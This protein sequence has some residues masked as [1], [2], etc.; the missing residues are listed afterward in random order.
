V[1]TQSRLVGQFNR[2]GAKLRPGLLKIQRLVVAI[3]FS[4]VTSFAGY[5]DQPAVNLWT[6]GGPYGGTVGRLAIDPTNSNIIYAAAF[7][8]GLYKSLDAGASWR[9]INTGI[10]P[11]PEVSDIVFDPR[12][13]STIYLASD[14]PLFKSMD[15]G[16]SWTS[17]ALVS[18]LPASISHIAIDPTNPTT[19]Y[20]VGAV[21]GTIHGQPP[22]AAVS[23]S[24]DGGVTWRLIKNDAPAL[25][26]QAV[27]IDPANPAT[28]YVGFSDGAGVYKTTDGGATWNQV[29]QGLGVASIAGLAFDPIS[30]GTLYANATT[31]FC[32]STKGGASWTSIGPPLT[33]FAQFTDVAITPDAI[34]LGCSPDGVFKSSNRGTSWVNI[35]FNGFAINSLVADSADDV[36]VGPGG[37]GVFKSVDGGGTWNSAS[38]GITDIALA[39]LAV[40]RRGFVYSTSPSS[41]IYK[42]M[43]NAQS[44]VSLD[45]A[46]SQLNETL[47]IDPVNP[48]VIYLGRVD[49]DHPVSLYKSMDAG[50][51]WVPSASG[52]GNQLVWSLVI[53]P[54]TPNT[55]YAGTGGGVY[56][57]TDAGA[58]WV[59]AS[60]GMPT[61]IVLALA[62]DPTDP[63]ILYAVTPLNG[64]VKSTNNGNSWAAVNAV[65]P[66]P[67]S[68]V[69]FGISAVILDPNHPGTI[70]VD[71]SSGVLKSIDGGGSWTA[72]NAGLPS[73]DLTAIAMDPSPSG[74]LYVAPL[75][76]GVY[77]ST[78]NGATWNSLNSGLGNLNVNAL[79]VNPL[80]PGTVF[81]A[82]QGG[83]YV[84]S[85]TA[86]GRTE[87]NFN[88]PGGAAI[89]TTTVG[90]GGLVRTGYASVTTNSGMPSDAVAVFS[91]TQ[92]GVV[93][94][95]AGVPASP[96]TP[97]VRILIDYRPSGSSKAGFLGSGSVSVD[98]GLA[99]V[100]AGVES[101]TI[102][103]L[104]LDPSGVEMARGHGTL[105]PGAHRALFID[106]LNQLAPD[107]VLPPNLGLAVEFASLEIQS[108]QPLSMVALRLSTNQ[109]GETLI[110]TTPIA[111]LTQ[112][113]SSAPLFFP[114][115]ADGGGYTTSL[116]FLNTSKTL[117]TGTIKVFADNGTPMSITPTG[118]STGPASLFSYAIPPG[119]VY[120]L[121]SNGSPEV[122]NVGSTEVIPDTGMQTPVGAGV[123]SLMQGGI[124]VTES[125][126]PSSIPTTHARIYVDESGG[127]DTGLAIASAS[128]SPMNIA[129]SAYRSDGVTQVGTGSVSL[130]GHGHVARFANQ[131]IPG[132]L[133]AGFTGVLDIDSSILFSS[134]PFVALTLR[135]LT[136]SRGDF[137]LTTF[138]IA[139][140]NQAPPAPIVFPQIAD[141]GGY[142]TQFIFLGINGSASNMTL[143]FFGDNGSALAVGKSAQLEIKK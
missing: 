65:F 32:V 99:V 141:G 112:T 21:V 118:V 45:A 17:L 117:E 121:H 111:D 22:S 116:F 37:T 124:L 89:A 28:V 81:A 79:A 132:G 110:T 139:D 90:A 91:L 56:K 3:V 52:L 43:D 41:T 102:T 73:L 133:P 137:L 40:D 100:N 7:P 29:N 135:S 47:A 113:P 30:P 27:A 127:H 97:S 96:P 77:F 39:A 94:S 60:L 82:T 129:V 33:N 67:P 64:L 1:G 13:S 19:M 48:A 10:S 75:N 2:D 108:D 15:G 54:M 115:L 128:G 119:G 136:N 83:I 14:G 23:K 69:A 85:S 72:I 58:T 109:R 138:P 35:G 24:I 92:N 25:F 38:I 20:G 49:S 107:F 44:W 34:Y 71:S 61:S 66:P 130:D 101:A 68:G 131:I 55:V 51:T 98:T 62:I 126:I 103:F 93:V 106:Q 123:F 140:F 36:Y 70:Y 31:A 76:S 95:E 84:F 18:S 104:L 125:G 12:T 8:A 114:Q 53:D 78:D 86:C 105:N 50:N 120:V 143:N 88:V 6:T 26:A 11:P 142:Q 5:R 80:C 63:S 57:S 87:L 42:S 46:P 122:V 134:S 9:P 59:A 16:Q 4:A 74:T